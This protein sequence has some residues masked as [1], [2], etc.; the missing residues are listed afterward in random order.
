LKKAPPEKKPPAAV[1]SRP[2]AT[3]KPPPAT[4]D[5]TKRAETPAAKPKPETAP[6]LGAGAV[7][8]AEKPFTIQVASL[9]EQKTANTMVDR[10]RAN[11]YP[12][13]R[14]RADIEG[15]G[16]W[17]RVRIGSFSGPADAAD[18][19]AQLKSAKLKPMLIRK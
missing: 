2:K 6:K 12:A 7:S 5:R 19:L 4:D 16:T 13:Y 10:L 15:K 17:H 9:K 1:D 3:P 8:A 18:T 11:G 14:E